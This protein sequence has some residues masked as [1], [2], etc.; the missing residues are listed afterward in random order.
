LLSAH[1]N[2]EQSSASQKVASPLYHMA[3]LICKQVIVVNPFKKIKNVHFWD[4]L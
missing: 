4:D 2:D 3:T 1:V